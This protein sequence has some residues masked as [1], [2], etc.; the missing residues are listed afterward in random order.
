M[1]RDWLRQA[2]IGIERLA[3]IRRD[4]VLQRLGEMES[5]RGW[6]RWI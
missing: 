3:E 6:E 5:N 2:E 1:V 4:G